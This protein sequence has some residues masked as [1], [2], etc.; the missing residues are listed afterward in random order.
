M[1]DLELK[2]R[3]LHGALSSKSLL[4]AL[5]KLTLNKEQI[6]IFK[7]KTKTNSYRHL[8]SKKWLPLRFR[9]QPVSGQDDEELQE[10]RRGAIL[11]LA[12]V[13]SLLGPAMSRMEAAA[14]LAGN[15]KATAPGA[16]WNPFSTVHTGAKSLGAHWSPSVSGFGGFFGAYAVPANDDAAIPGVSNVAAGEAVFTASTVVDGELSPGT[17]PNH[18]GGTGGGA[19]SAPAFGVAAV[20]GVSFSGADPLDANSPCAPAAAAG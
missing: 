6:E 5:E 16:C 17:C 2:R 18:A 7:E 8:G 14:A 3:K 15:M 13:W 12:G 11:R 9:D 1:S 20:A 10:A 4:E 19:F